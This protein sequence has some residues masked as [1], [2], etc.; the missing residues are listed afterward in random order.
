VILRRTRAALLALLTG[1]VLPAWSPRF[2]EAQT[3]LALNLIPRRMAAF[4]KQYPAALRDG[5]RGVANDQVPTPED[6]EA[7]FARILELSENQGRPERIVRELGTLAHM[8]QLLIDPSATAGV[9]PLREQF[10]AYGDEHLPRLTVNREP[11]W[12]VTSS[13][14]PRPQLLKWSEVKYQR[15]RILLQNFD[16][17]TGRRTG[18]WDILSSP[19]AQLQLAYSN[20][21][22]A[23][24]NLWIQAWRAAGADWDLPN[25]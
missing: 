17:A 25:P 7:Q 8:A 9:T 23:T 18:S 11:F 16:L 3:A 1:T 15:H 12:A 19:F 13:L 22:N 2:H 4:L 20:G 14:D 6:V 21:V 10:E 5:A 24:A